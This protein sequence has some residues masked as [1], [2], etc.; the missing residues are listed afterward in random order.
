MAN[1]LSTMGK[2]SVNATLLKDIKVNNEY[3][4]L[5]FYYIEDEE[6][7]LIMHFDK[8]EDA[9]TTMRL[10]KE[11]LLQAQLEIDNE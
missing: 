1:Y 6:P 9:Y 4:T 10:F 2:I 8:L 11:K 3:Y 7:C 5:E